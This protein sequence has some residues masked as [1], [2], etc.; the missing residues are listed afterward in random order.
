MPFQGSFYLLFGQ[1]RLF[2]ISVGRKS[3]K[4][5]SPIKVTL[6]HN[7]GT[8]KKFKKGTKKMGYNCIST[9]LSN[10][11]SILVVG[12]GMLSVRD[13]LGNSVDWVR[14]VLNSD[15]LNPSALASV[16]EEVAL[17]KRICILRPSSPLYRQMLHRVVGS[18]LKPVPPKCPN[19]GPQQRAGT[20]SAKKH[21]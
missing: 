17:R 18:M 6:D 3:T 4:V 1:V 20:R 15:L 12:T 16:E 21:R 9:T 7:A 11:T 13:V 8:V 2:R 5:R 19:R 14:R 10:G